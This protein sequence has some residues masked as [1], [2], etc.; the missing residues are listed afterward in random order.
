MATVDHKV[1]AWLMRERPGLVEADDPGACLRKAWAMAGVECSVEDFRAALDHAGF[2]VD[3]VRRTFR[4]ALPS[5]P[6][7]HRLR[8]IQS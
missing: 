8:N 5:K 3:Q 7:D 6:M 4:L 1:R 2:R